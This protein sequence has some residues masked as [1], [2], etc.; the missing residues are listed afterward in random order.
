MISPDQSLAQLAV[1]GMV[2]KEAA[3]EKAS[4]PTMFEQFLGHFEAERM[5][6]TGAAGAAKGN[7]TGQAP[8]PAH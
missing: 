6:A 1:T 4:I 2:T 8:P 7:G 5:G 3:R